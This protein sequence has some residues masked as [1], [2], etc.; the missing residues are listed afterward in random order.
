MVLFPLLPFII[1]SLRIHFLP[2]LLLFYLFPFFP[3]T[4]TAFLTI[5][6]W[7]NTFYMFLVV[8]CA[9]NISILG[10]FS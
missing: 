9:I 10:L 2:S 6:I 8:H 4:I 1:T 7:Y 3:E 5:L